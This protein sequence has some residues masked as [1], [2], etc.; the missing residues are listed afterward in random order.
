M[1][2]LQNKEAL[3]QPIKDYWEYVGCK[4]IH[5]FDEI[6]K[7]LND[8]K[9]IN[10]Y[11]SHIDNA[12]YHSINYYDNINLMLFINLS[13]S[14]SYNYY[15]QYL[16]DTH[17]IYGIK[18]MNI[19]F[20]L[21]PKILYQIKYQH[22][23]NYYDL[24]K[25]INE[26]YPFVEKYNKEYIEINILFLINRQSNVYIPV[27]SLDLNNDDLQYISIYNRDNYQKKVISS[28]FYNENS[29]KFLELQNL[30]KILSKDF[31]SNLVEF[32]KIK[33]E[34]LKYDYFTQENIMICSSTILML[35]GMRKNND[36]DVYIDNVKNPD[37][38]IHHFKSMSNLDFQVKNTEH[39]PIYWDKWLDEW[40]QKSGAKYFEEIV[41]FHEY[42]FHYCG[43]KFISIDVD[44]QRRITRRR[45]AS[46]ADIF[47]LNKIHNMNITMPTI[48]EKKNKLQSVEKLSE[49]EKKK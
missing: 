18:T 33:E 26:D 27:H 29:I 48:P 10:H 31:Q 39:W 24:M 25:N 30:Q 46:C 12:C 3:F 20:Q 11:N 47:M 38:L 8:N 43:I 19:S 14:K 41:G 42:H 44:I 34:F 49:K 36:I 45:P 6:N 37:K 35:L 21:L 17:K 32:H 16:K 40:A 22:I 5:L 13:K 28:I 1:S 9:L 4:N 15:V 23:D 7:I 2:I